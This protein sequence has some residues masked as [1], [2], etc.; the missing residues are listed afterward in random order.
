[1]ISFLLFFVVEI[2]IVESLFRLKK[3][4]FKTPWIGKMFTQCDDCKTFGKC[5]DVGNIYCG[6]CLD[7]MANCEYCNCITR[8]DIKIESSHNRIHLTICKTC[9]DIHSTKCDG[10][11]KS[12]VR[13][14]SY[15]YD[16]GRY[17]SSCFDETYAYCD[18]CGDVFPQ[19]ALD[20]D[21]YCTRCARNHRPKEFINITGKNWDFDK[22]YGLELECVGED[23]CGEWI[24]VHDGSIDPAGTEYCSPIFSGDCLEE[25]QRFCKIANRNHDIN[26]TCGYHLHL[27]SKGLTDEFL[28]KLYKRCI[29]MENWFFSIVSPSRRESKYCK[30]LEKGWTN[31]EEKRFDLL[32]YNDMM[33][34]RRKRDKYDATRYQWINFHSHYY[35][36]TVEIRLHQGTLDPDKIWNWILLW[37]HMFKY[38]GESINPTD[39]F[40]KD[41]LD[42][43]EE[44]AKAFNAE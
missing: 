41:L 3:I 38:E 16:G 5:S 20:D 43:Y 42:Y 12:I 35:R 4:W 1:M 22:T 26:K 14:D 44:R 33:P 8:A 17:C 28:K 32:W 40:P 2:Y 25:I 36:G 6:K 10:C 15:N 19:D 30:R 37:Q 9:K 11:E 7:K 29:N 24:D 31:I 23:Y 21:N 27:G 18:D 39:I 13:Y 34:D